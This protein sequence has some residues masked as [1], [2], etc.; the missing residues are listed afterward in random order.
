MPS[1]T[2]SMP[3]PHT[4]THPRAR[5]LRTHDT[6]RSHQLSIAVSTGGPNDITG[7]GVAGET[8]V[9]AQL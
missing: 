4:R 5:R 3:P 1:A 7:E 6:V 8:A 9:G 2:T